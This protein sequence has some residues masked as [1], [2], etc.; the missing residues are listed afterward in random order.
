[1]SDDYPAPD[2]FD[3]NETAYEEMLKTME[4]KPFFERLKM[5]FEGFTK[6]K[7]SGEYKIAKQQLE[8]MTSPII[9][10]ITV[11][12]LVVVM[13]LIAPAKDADARAHVAE[14]VQPETVQDMEEPPPP[15]EIEPP[16]VMDFDPEITDVNVNNVTVNAPVNAPMSAKPSNVNAVAL[17][18][19]PITMTGVYGARTTGQ[20]GAARA[21]F[22]GSPEVEACVMRSL[23]WLK[24]KQ[25]QDGSWSNVRPAMTGLAILTFLAHGEMPGKSPEFGDTVRKGLQ[26]LI[27]TQDKGGFF[28]GEDGNKYAHHIATYALCEAYAMTRN[29]EVKEA[30]EKAVIPIIKGQHAN[31][32]WDYKIAITDRDD[33]SVMGWASQAIK[34]AH[35]CGDLLSDPEY[36][37]IMTTDG[38][39][40]SLEAA[41]QLAPK[42]F[43]KNFHPEGGF[44]YTGKH[45]TSGLSAVGTLCMQLMGQGGHDAVKKTLKVMDDWT[46]GWGGSG[47][48]IEDKK[49]G[50]KKALPLPDG[51]ATFKQHVGDGACP[52]YYAY[53]ATQCMFQAGG[54]RW[55]R[56][57]KM[58]S[59]VYPKVQI[60]SSKE[61]SGY[62]DHKG[63]PQEIGYYQNDDQHSD[64]PVMDTCLATLQLEVYY[65]YLPTFKEVKVDNADI[66]IGDSAKDVGVEI[67]F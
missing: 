35:N 56:W 60:I 19:S 54:E 9:A 31:G 42:G 55:T 26:Y 33:T 12:A 16:E 2:Y 49:T 21:K 6:P 24:K 67:E 41:Y 50:T 44:G 38:R 47:A 3:K 51:V 59:A 63:Q 13:F 39:K 10:F 57:N 52:Q 22:G 65:R 64:R 18:K 28:K 5:M 66:V 7:D 8:L 48:M 37:T 20:I 11:S 61:T 15:E 34:A 45:H 46:I 14:V 62:V 43:L 58:M 40:S 29:P 17:V 32:G 25:N 53:Y 27:S 36:E 30:A 23:R 4:E 1:M